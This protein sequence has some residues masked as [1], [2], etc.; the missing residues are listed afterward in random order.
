MHTILAVFVAKYDTIVN[1]KYI[2]EKQIE[3]NGVMI[4]L[5]DDQ[6]KKVLEQ[7]KVKNTKELVKQEILEMLEKYKSN[8]RFLDKNWKESKYPTSRFEIFNENGVWLF[9]IDY[10]EKNQHFWYSYDR[11]WGVFYEKYSIN[12][13]DFQDVMKSV[14]EEHLNLKGVTPQGTQFRFVTRLGKHLNLNGVT[15]NHGN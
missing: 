8:V 10:N 12:Y 9:D 1:N 2:M 5:T 13:Y 15:P 7:T 6:I 4:E 3:V 11:V 14:L